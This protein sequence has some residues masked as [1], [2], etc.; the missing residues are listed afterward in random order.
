MV[1]NGIVR[2]NC[3]IC[4]CDCG[5]LA[6]LEDG[7][8]TKI[9]GDPDSPTNKG[10]L[11]PKG[12][13]SLEFLN[14]PS[15]LR[16]PLRRAGERGEGKW[17]TIS[18]DEALGTL[19]DEMNKARAEHGPESVLWLRGAAKGMQDN[20][21]TRLANTF[22]S[23]NITS[24][25]YV[26]FHP[27]MNA[28]K[29][30][31]G[32]S[33]SQDYDY[34]PACIIVWGADPQG[35][36]PPVY[37]A[38]RRAQAKGAKVVVIDPFETDLAKGATLWLRPRP[39]T[40][41][42]LALG[43]IHVIIK[44]G[45]VDQGFVDRWTIGFDKLVPHIQSYTPER[46]EEITWVS[47]KILREAAKL[48]GTTKPGVIEAGNAVEQIQHSLQ[49]SRAIFILEALCGNIGVPGGEIKWMRP[50]LAN[51]S[52]PEFTRQH[53]IPKEKR[54]NRLGVE[55]LA[56]FIH[57][58]LPQGMVKALLAGK[59]Y[60]PRVAY[61]QGA[62]V[63]NTW[64]NAWETR[65]AF[66]KLRFI[67]AADFFMTPTTELCDIVLPSAHYL[68]YDAVHHMLFPFAAQVQQ[69]V[70][71]P[72]ECWSDVKICLEL[73]KRLDLGEFFWNDEQEFLN[74]VL[75]PS[76]ITFQ[77]FKEI[78]LLHGVKQY[79]FYETNGFGT[80]SGKVEIYSKFLEENGADPLP[81]YREP[82]ETPYSDPVLAKEYPL[83]LTSR[84][85]G[86]FRHTNL[87]QIRSL[88]SG[89]PDPILNIHPGTARKLGIKEGDWVYIENKQGKI[90]HKAEYTESLDPRVVVGD[91]GWWYPE[92]GIEDLHGF[93]VSSI[94]AL[95]SNK[96][97]FS[98]EM[99]TPIFRGLMCKVYKK[100]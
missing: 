91:H 15:R 30:T 3:A 18:W 51:L 97:P 81:T 25:A 85:P 26:C 63:F 2:T 76:H 71:D 6:H 53:S 45:L 19:A 93:V 42:A 99:G 44:E 47:A 72:G 28:M 14:H 27:R 17:S 54:N 37:N 80:P 75:K 35:T 65:E 50:P 87:R 77:E 20:V 41:M 83:I 23:P 32:D 70:V 7:R 98:P 68:E 59:P 89:R 88:R 82:H 22:G 11:C 46:V 52:S 61:L 84:K 1:K 24:M 90:T 8:I 56:P 60:M 4:H 64:S 62:N 66:L 79:R 95:T 58:A 21:F 40:D 43:M 10:V 38:I 100:T 33:I 39:A 49:A 74:E 5:V 13:A 29:L 92:K 67:A 73:S 55:Y 78:G 31:V 12:L 69:A 34:P 57:Y 16:H 36:T 86:L 96:P 48:Y 94:N 9:E